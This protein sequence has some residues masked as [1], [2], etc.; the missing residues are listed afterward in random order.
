[1]ETDLLC[2]TKQVADKIVN[3][4]SAQVVN[5][6]I[7]HSEIPSLPESSTSKYNGKF[8]ISDSGENRYI[9]DDYDDLEELKVPPSSLYVLSL[10]FITLSTSEFDYFVVLDSVAFRS[11]AEIDAV[12]SAFQSADEDEQF[13]IKKYGL[14]IPAFSVPYTLWP[15]NLNRPIPSSVGEIK[16]VFK[17]ALNEASPSLDHLQEDLLQRL[18]ITSAK[19]QSG[20]KIHR[21]L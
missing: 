11:P 18:G 19:V 7:N 2:Q 10:Y 17:E 21:I 9:L 16:E 5:L 15:V 1:M 3:I 20:K 8:F 13:L 14:H 6:T 4:E 12:S